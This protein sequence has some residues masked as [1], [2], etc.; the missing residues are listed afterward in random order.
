[1]R[2]C[3]IPVQLVI[4]ES[5]Q[6]C[7]TYEKQ[8][9][10]LNKKVNNLQNSGDNVDLKCDFLD[11]HCGFYENYGTVRHD[12]SGIINTFKFYPDFYESAGDDEV[13]CMTGMLVCSLK[14]K[15]GIWDL[16]TSGRPIKILFPGNSLFDLNN[17]DIKLKCSNYA[18]EFNAL[19]RENDTTD[20]L[21][22]FQQHA[23]SYETIN[24][25]SFNKFSLPGGTSYNTNKIMNLHA[26]A[27]VRSFLYSTHK[28]SIDDLRKL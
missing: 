26:M 12:F 7:Y 15:N 23:D 6:E 17:S 4:P 11:A 18:N 28:F 20:N 1:M 5:F 16:Q 9:M 3:N 22:Y 8:I 10:Y 2:N 14:I 24:S 21:T 27:C 25:K 19:F 13:Y